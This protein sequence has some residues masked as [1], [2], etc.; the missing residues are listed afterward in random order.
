[1]ESVS[2]H[3]LEGGGGPGA[4]QA[5]HG[6]KVRRQLGVQLE[7]RDKSSSDARGKREE[8]E[9]KHARKALRSKASTELACLN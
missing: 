1:M 9:A 2:S 8:G 6:K 4:P 3:G 7:N 5:D